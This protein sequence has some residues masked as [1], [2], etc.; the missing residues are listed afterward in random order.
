MTS[1]SFVLTL[2]STQTLEQPLPWMSMDGANGIHV[3]AT[4]LSIGQ[5]AGTATYDIIVEISNDQTNSA[6]FN[7]MVFGADATVL[8]KF[9]GVGVQQ[10]TVAPN[11]PTL[12]LSSGG[13]NLTN[14][15]SIGSSWVRIAIKILAPR[16][17]RSDL[18]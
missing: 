12:A 3:Q 17:M 9:T 6:N 7:G 13:S 10:E 18:G 16:H 5:T 8:M 11:A 15:A 2:S 4:C 1:G 14:K